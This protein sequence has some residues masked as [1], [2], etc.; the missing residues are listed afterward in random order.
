MSSSEDS[1]D[2]VLRALRQIIH[3]VD[4]HSRHLVRSHRLTSPQTLVLTKLLRNEGLVISEL[5]KRI[6]LSQATLT[7]ILN[8]LER[9][10]LVQRNRSEVDK[11]RVYVAATERARELLRARPRCCR[12]AFWRRSAP[13]PTGSRICSCPRCSASQP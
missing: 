4:L 8:R 13:C 6:S 11:R 2:R 9:R 5:A 10:G 3:A 7:D 12:N 1:S